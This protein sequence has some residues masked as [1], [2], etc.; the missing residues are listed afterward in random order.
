MPRWD[1][2]VRLLPFT[3]W[4]GWGLCVREQLGQLQGC[5]QLETQGKQGE[6]KLCLKL[7]FNS[8]LICGFFT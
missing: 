2:A 6:A 7:Y 5:E 3:T 8:C 4:E 1:Q